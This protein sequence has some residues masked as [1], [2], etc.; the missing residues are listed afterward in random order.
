[1]KWL[2]FHSFIELR[3]GITPDLYILLSFLYQ[4]VVKR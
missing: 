1:M 3:I 2:Q 4:Q